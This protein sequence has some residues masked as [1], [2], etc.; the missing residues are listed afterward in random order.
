[1]ETH[2]LSALCCVISVVLMLCSYGGAQDKR[3]LSLKNA[4]MEEKSTAQI[5]MPQR[6]RREN[7]ATILELKHHSSCSMPNRTPQ[8][9]L[10][11][12]FDS[13]DKRVS[14]W[15]SRIRGVDLKSSS[16]ADI[17]L[18][19]GVQ[20]QTLNYIVTIKIVHAT[21]KKIL[22]SIPQPLL[23]ISPY[24]ANSPTCSS[25]QIATGISFSCGIDQP[26]C[27]YS[28]SYGDGSYTSGVLGWE[29]IDLAGTIIDGFVFGCGQTNHGL[30][31]GTSGLVG[32]GRTQLSLVSQTIPQFGGI[33]SY[34]LPPKEY[35]SSGSLVLGGDPSIFKNTTPVSYT[36]IISDPLESPFYF[37]NLTGISIGTVPLQASGFHKKV[38]IDSGTVISRLVPSVYKALRDEFK[39]QFSI[40]PM[41]PGFSILDTCFN[42]AGHEEVSI[43]AI[44][45][46]F[47]GD[48]EV[49]VDASGI[50]YFVKLDS[51]Q[52]CL[53]ISSLPFEDDVAIIGNYQQKNLRV[54]YD[55]LGSRLGFAEETCDWL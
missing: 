4:G 41:A 39:R 26:S 14:S 23:P 20:L 54:V 35:D 13:D 45:L 1:M 27:N 36:R 19:S 11:K 31:G 18:T 43:P 51:S 42:L 2:K 48:V 52:V 16:E 30:F 33:F 32:L 49:D 5:C 12:M 40:Y 9:N 53:A 50:L 37:L 24:S 46:V 8:L 28:L 22:Y 29:Q 44:K 47:E 7:G 6:S 38:I 17:P 10:S 3:V 25:V 21:A 34:C 15:T 55:T